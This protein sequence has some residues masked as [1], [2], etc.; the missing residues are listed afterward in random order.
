MAETLRDDAGC[1]ASSCH[2]LCIAQ[3]KISHACDD[4]GNETNGQELFDPGPIQ[5]V[6]NSYLGRF[7]RE[8]DVFPNR[9]QS[10]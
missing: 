10:R 3:Q 7:V 9:L 5:V 1:K 6:I 2:F 8:R 4:R